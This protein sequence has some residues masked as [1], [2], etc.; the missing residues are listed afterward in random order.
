M[1][2]W[3]PMAANVSSPS[4]GRRM[5][6]SVCMQIE[7]Y[8]IC[9]EISR[10]LYAPMCICIIVHMDAFQTLA[11][12]T[13]RQIVETL[14]GGEQQVNDIV[15]AL[16][17][18]QSG[19]S[20]HLRLLLKAGFVQVRPAGQM[21]LYSLRPEPFRELEAWVA[22]YQQVWDA[23]LTR[24]GAALEKRRAVNAATAQ[25]QRKKGNENDD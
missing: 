18:H 8:A 19:V 17:I 25:R 13:R 10:C 20:R 7:L 14:R 3:L 23:R 6:F 22:S 1:S 4:S 5:S 21:R 11:D 16:D 24:F 9:L 2:S 12:H 15:D